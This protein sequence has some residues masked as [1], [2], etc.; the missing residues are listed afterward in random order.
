MEPE[1]KMSEYSTDE[2]V[3][4]VEGIA[5]G[6]HECCPPLAI[7]ARLRD[8]DRVADSLGEPLDGLDAN[9]DPDVL[10]YSDKQWNAAITKARTAIADCETGE[11]EK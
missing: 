3:K 6:F 4:W 8:S 7:I 9:L 2:L 11:K 10:G 1:G 5:P